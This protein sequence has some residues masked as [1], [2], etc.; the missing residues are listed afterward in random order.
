MKNNYTKNII[1]TSSITAIIF[2][3]LLFLIYIIYCYGFYDKW[4]ENNLI[5]NYNNNKYDYIFNH[6]E[7]NE[8]NLTRTN[9]DKIINQTFNKDKLLSIYNTYYKDALTEEEFLNR[10][11]FG[12]IKI[13]KEN[14]IIKKENKTTLFKRAKINYDKVALNKENTKTILGIINNIKINIEDDSLLYIDD[15]LLECDKECN[16]DKIYGGIHTIKYIKDDYIYYGLLNLY[17]D[18]KEIN[19]LSIDSLV[20]EEKKGTIKTNGTNRNY[21]SLKTGHY[22]LKECYL[23]SSCPTSQK[24][25][26]DLNEDN[27]IELYT[28]INLD[29]A[30]DLYKGTYKIDNGFLIMQF[31]NH[32]YHVF[33]YDT[34]EGTDIDVETN[35]EFRY[36]ILENNEIQNN[37]FR[38]KLEE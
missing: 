17:E 37:Q 29:Q 15:N 24:S 8:E 16:I 9:Y 5:E 21:N 1:I 18:N 13:T 33:D 27:T 11:Y 12:N 30:G 34:K 22:K 7:Q 28:Y 31:N 26:L 14:L 10:Y 20:L 2:L 23:S 32:T 4:Q 35:I 38:F 6:L 3:F 25:Y 36:K 19:I